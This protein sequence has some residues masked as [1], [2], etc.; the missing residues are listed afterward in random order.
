MKIETYYDDKKFEKEQSLKEFK[1]FVNLKN[2]HEQIKELVHDTT[3]NNENIN[4]I[5]DSKKI[6]DFLNRKAKYFNSKKWKELR[7]RIRE[8]DCNM[9]VICGSE[10]RLQVHHKTYVRFENEDEDDLVTLC[11][12]CHSD[13][14]KE[15]GKPNYANDLEGQWF[16]SDYLEDIRIRNYKQRQ[17]L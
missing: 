9:C 8:R 13:L 12:K 4:Y 7:A 11:N 14:H 15:L 1:Q 2:Q 6:N 5:S 10:D 16:W 17:I 3:I